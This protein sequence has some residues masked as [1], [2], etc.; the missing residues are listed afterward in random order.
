M[1]IAVYKAASRANRQHPTLY[2][3]ADTVNILAVS[4]EISLTA[5]CEATRSNSKACL[6]FDLD[7]NKI[8]T[9]TD[10]ILQHIVRALISCFPHFRGWNYNAYTVGHYNGAIHGLLLSPLCLRVPHIDRMRVYAD[11]RTGDSAA[12]TVGGIDGVPF[13]PFLRGQATIKIIEL[14]FVEKLPIALRCSLRRLNGH[15]CLQ[16][17]REHFLFGNLFL[18]FLDTP[19]T[20]F[21][22]GNRCALRRHRLRFF[23]E[24][25]AVLR[26]FLCL[27]V[28]F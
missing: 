14:Q 3:T 11:N 1:S 17:R 15:G 23:R 21:G 2:A 28:Q 6:T 5:A 22:A 9:R 18:R 13:L 4:E 16:R 7:D 19:V 27:V 10:H 25:Y 8:D 12:S 26:R 20:L 24:I